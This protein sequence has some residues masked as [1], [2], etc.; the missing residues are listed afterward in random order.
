MEKRAPIGI[1][2]AMEVEV[3]S[4]IAKLGGDES[5]SVAGLVFHR[6]EL[7]G[8]PVVVAECGPGKVNEY[9]R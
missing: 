5:D 8:V 3:D 4:I 2:G 1:I 6:G 7:E 9:Q